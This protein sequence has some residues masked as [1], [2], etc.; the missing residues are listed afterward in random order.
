MTV[1]TQINRKELERLVAQYDIGP[2]IDFEGLMA[3]QANSNFKLS[4]RTGNYI[5]SVCDEKDFS[6]VEQLTGF[7]F[8]LEENGFKTTRVLKSKNGD[9]VVRHRNKP[10]FLKYFLEGAIPDEISE[11]KARRLGRE[12]AR[13]HQIKSPP[14]LP[15]RFAY[16]L[17]CFGEVIDS[18]A[19]S[20]YRLWLEAKMEYIEE[21]ISPEL[22]RSIV[23]GDIFYDNTLFNGDELVAVIDFEEACH[24]Y[25]IFDLGMC[26]VG[27]C[28][29]ADG[30]DFGKTRSLVEG[31]AE[32]ENLRKLEAESFQAF[33]VYAATAASFWRF[34]QYNLLFPNHGKSKTYKPMNIMADQLLAMPPDEFMRA[35]FS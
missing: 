32:I 16:G 22:P 29:E 23:H 28:A 24:Y 10:A 33:I 20:D 6:E 19:D 9:R 13:L 21:A 8:Y 30:L 14:G 18:F 17:E 7:L 11:H 3:G 27:S 35:I 25:R 15:S 2:L 5:L 26:A 4:T 31:Y 12:I 1:Y 34:R